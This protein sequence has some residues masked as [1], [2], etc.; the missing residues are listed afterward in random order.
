MNLPGQ[1]SAAVLRRSSGDCL[2]RI[3]RLSKN[4]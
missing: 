1:A 4:I 2:K 3:E